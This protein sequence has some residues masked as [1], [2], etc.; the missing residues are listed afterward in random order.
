MGP[1]VVGGWGP[2]EDSI[3][4]TAPG[5]LY[6]EFLRVTDW[7]GLLDAFLAV[8]QAGRS[9]RCRTAQ[10]STR[11]TSAPQGCSVQLASPT[12]QAPLENVV[13]ANRI[14]A[15]WRV[16]VRHKAWSLYGLERRCVLLP[17][18]G[19]LFDLQTDALDWTLLVHSN[20]QRRGQRQ[21]MFARALAGLLPRN[22]ASLVLCAWH[23][24]WARDMGTPNWPA[25]GHS[26]VFQH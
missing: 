14:R 16:A 1:G 20:L 21:S 26:A 24:T 23:M 22:R 2:A 15:S 19:A 12:R 25:G 8:H 18:A 13:Q 10:W 7:Q 3:V 11:P 4:S 17:P 6:I 9:R 5:L